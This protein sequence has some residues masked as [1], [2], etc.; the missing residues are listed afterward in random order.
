MLDP[1]GRLQDPRLNE[2]ERLTVID[3]PLGL[4]ML[5]TWLNGPS[6]MYLAET[7]APSGVTS[8]KQ[9]SNGVHD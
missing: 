2:Q 5:K 9:S 8:T 7:P 6:L 4:K 1:P 3:E